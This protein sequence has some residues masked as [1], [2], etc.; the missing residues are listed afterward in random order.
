MQHQDLRLLL[1]GVLAGLAVGCTSVDSEPEAAFGALSPQA[2]P[3]DVVFESMVDAV[4]SQEFE[5]HSSQRLGETAEFKTAFKITGK[6]KITSVEEGK[7][8]RVRIAP[9]GESFSVAM[10]ACVFSR[11]TPADSWVYMARDEALAE[12]IERSLSGIL[13][14]RY[15]GGGD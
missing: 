7:R 8:V 1:V 15:Q 9:V 14:Q 4:Q 2:Y 12:R 3:F 11:D 5:I 13:T 6:D 10:A